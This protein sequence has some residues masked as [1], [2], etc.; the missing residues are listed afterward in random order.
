MLFD[1]RR[2]VL[3]GLVLSICGSVHAENWPSWARRRQSS[4]TGTEC[5]VKWAQMLMSKS[6]EFIG[7][8]LESLPNQKSVRLLGR[9]W[10]K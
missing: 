8:R 10:N 3:I 9:R 7:S 1:S 6:N 5:G 4:R 2:F